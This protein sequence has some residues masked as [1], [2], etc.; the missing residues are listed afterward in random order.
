MRKNLVSNIKKVLS[1]LK[2]YYVW[3]LKN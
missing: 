2:K 3:E 1:D